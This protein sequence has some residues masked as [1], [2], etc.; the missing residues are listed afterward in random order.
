MTGRVWYDCQPCGIRY[1]D[2]IHDDCPECGNPDTIP[3]AS[4][5]AIKLV[6]LNDE[7]PGRITIDFFS[8]E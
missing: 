7:P 3:T 1:S 4:N 5:T 8:D 2:I 6:S